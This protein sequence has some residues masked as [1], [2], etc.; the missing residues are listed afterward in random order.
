[1][2]DSWSAQVLPRLGEVY[3]GHEPQLYGVSF[4]KQPFPNH[5]RKAETRFPSSN[6]ILDY[7]SGLPVDP[8]MSNLLCLQYLRLREG[9]NPIRPESLG[10]QI[11]WTFKALEAYCRKGL[12]ARRDKPHMDTPRQLVIPLSLLFWTIRALTSG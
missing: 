12:M 2:T 5:V 11:G 6:T 10:K 1:M 3:D 7:Q 9:M 4:R 8:Q